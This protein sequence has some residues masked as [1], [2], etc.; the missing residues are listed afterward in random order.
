METSLSPSVTRVLIDEVGEISVMNARRSTLSLGESDW[1]LDL[2]DSGKCKERPNFPGG[3]VI[4]NL[5]YRILRKVGKIWLG[6][7]VRNKEHMV[8]MVM[9]NAPPPCPFSISYRARYS[10]TKIKRD[11]NLSAPNEV[12]EESY[13]TLIDAVSVY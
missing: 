13:Y 4:L 2:V 5:V 10:S 9:Y 7:C 3:A 1:P 12:L 6:V 11:S 8:I